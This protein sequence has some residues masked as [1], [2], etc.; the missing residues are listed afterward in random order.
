M[1]AD[2]HNGHYESDTLIK[3]P[4]YGGFFNRNYSWIL[5]Q[6]EARLFR[7][8]QETM[9]QIWENIA[10]LFKY[11]QRLS[12]IGLSHRIRPAMVLAFIRA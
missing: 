5:L 10:A 3:K 11:C 6:A 12:G 8:E 9:V 7:V 2:A 1:V 4:P